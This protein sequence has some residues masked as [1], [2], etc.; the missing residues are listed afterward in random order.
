[1]PW[2]Q[3]FE[4]RNLNSEPYCCP[5]KGTGYAF[6]PS[7]AD[8]CCIAS[9]SSKARCTQNTWK[10]M[11]SHFHR[12]A[13]KLSSVVESGRESKACIC[14]NCCSW[15]CELRRRFA[16][17]LGLWAHQKGA[18]WTD[19]KAWAVSK[20]SNLCRTRR[21]QTA[22]GPTASDTEGTVLTSTEVPDSK[23]RLGC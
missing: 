3:K 15:R 18:R 14:Y 17:L 7:V 16:R 22:A 12:I 13:V 5:W 1:M 4:F 21:S 2:I 19:A 20:C 6:F 23:K 9:L 10:I 8:T 11:Y